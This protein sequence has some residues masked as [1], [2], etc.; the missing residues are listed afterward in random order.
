[1]ANI[2]N[3]K[4]QIWIAPFR[5]GLV[6]AEYPHHFYGN[7]RLLLEYVSELTHFPLN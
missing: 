1:M 5:N 3:R 4:F 2:L 6:E 7:L